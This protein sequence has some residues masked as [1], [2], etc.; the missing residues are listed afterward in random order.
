MPT[1]EICIAVFDLNGTLYTKK[2]KDEFFK[3]ICSKKLSKAR[4]I[5]QMAY[6]QLRLKLHTLSQTEFKENFF[7]YLDKIPPKQVTV[8][9]KEY[10]AKE[11]PGEFNKKLI[12]RLEALRKKG[13]KIYCATGALELYVKPLFELYPVDG[14]VGTQ[15]EYVNDTYLVKGEACKG[16]EKIRRLEQQ[17]KGKPYKIVEAYSDS[18]EPILDKAQKAFLVKDGKIIPYSSSD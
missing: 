16:E 14:L 11:Y 1:D 4:Y 15:V 6:Y 13:I 9:A 7:N 3:F 12:D 5:F 18:K 2:S 17:L 10:W 8:F